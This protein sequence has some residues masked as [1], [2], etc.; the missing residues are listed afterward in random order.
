VADGL[1]SAP[2]GHLP[3]GRAVT[4]FTLS[5]RN[6]TSVEILDYGGIVT[7]LRVADRDGRHDN[8]VLGCGSLEDYCADRAF[9][10]ALIGRYA[11]RI[12]HGGFSLDGTHYRLACND[13]PHALHGGPQGYNRA[14]WRA[15]AVEH[16]D[17]PVLALH[18]VSPDGDAGYPGTLTIEVHYAL[19]ADDALR[20]DYTA[21]TDRPTIVN[22][23]NHSY[24]NL[25]GEGS[26][27]V[28]G[29]ELMIAADAFTPVDATLIPSGEIGPVAGTPFDFRDAT[30]IGKNIRAGDEQIFRGRGF[31]HNFVLRPAAAGALRPAAWV[32]DPRTGRVLEV[33]TTEPGLQLYSGNFLD[34]TRPG[35]AG[36]AYRQGD[37]L[38]LET[39]H[40][41]DSPHRSEFPDTVLR[42]GQTF[43]STTVYRFRID[44]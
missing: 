31:D 5:N 12:A 24:F 40:F 1:A 44:R 10:G 30:P 42:P 13:P 34:G 41:P 14:L 23:T 3:D 16:A 15:E 36:R 19:G 7:S 22:L 8:V 39:Q 38:C 11:N 29:H 6:G 21:A 4:R 37:G 26:G 28:Y 33:S 2:Y 18:H 43:R 32:R 20:I 27:D 17:G 35:T 25:A 9:F